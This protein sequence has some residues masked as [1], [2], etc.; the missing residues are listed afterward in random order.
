MKRLKSKFYF[1]LKLY[2]NNSKLKFYELF[3]KF[4]NKT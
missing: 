4:W 3:L 1:I 2:L